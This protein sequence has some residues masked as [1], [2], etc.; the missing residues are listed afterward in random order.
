MSKLAEVAIAAGICALVFT[1]LLMGLAYVGA[2]FA[3]L[4]IISWPHAGA[5]LGAA[6]LALIFAALGFALYW[7]QSADPRSG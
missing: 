3:L 2:C 4:G 5:M 6:G 7:V 1:A